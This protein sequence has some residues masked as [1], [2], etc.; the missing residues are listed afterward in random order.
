[1]KRD[2]YDDTEYYRVAHFCNGL[3]KRQLKHALV[4]AKRDAVVQEKT[5]MLDVERAKLEAKEEAFKE[6]KEELKSLN[7]MMIM[8]IQALQKNKGID[9]N[10]KNAG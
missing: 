5:R 3:T 7:D 10:V 6:I 1:M 9:I 4:E 2:D 8:L